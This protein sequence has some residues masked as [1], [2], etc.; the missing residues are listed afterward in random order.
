MI[1]VIFHLA[2]WYYLIEK[3]EPELGAGVNPGQNVIN[4]LGAYLGI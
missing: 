4:V 2:I 1:F 3:I